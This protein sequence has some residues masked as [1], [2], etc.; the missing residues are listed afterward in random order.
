MKSRAFTLI[1]LLVVIAIIALLVGILLP[2]L[3]KARQASRLSV[4][5]SN[6]RQQMIATHTYRTDNR[7]RLPMPVV[8]LPGSPAAIAPNAMG[9][10]YSDN[11]SWYGPNRVPPNSNARPGSF[12]YWPGERVLNPYIYP[13]LDLPKRPTSPQP[14]VSMRRAGSYEAF[15]SP[16]DL[17][18][19]FTDTGPGLLFNPQMTTYQDIGSSYSMNT[20]WFISYINYSPRPFG[21][22][23]N[24]PEQWERLERKASRMIGNGTTNTSKFVW[25]FDKTAL[26]FFDSSNP[27]IEGEFMGKNKCVMGF[28]DGHADYV[29][30][31]RRTVPLGGH[32]L[33]PRG[34]GNLQ[35]GTYR[36]TNNALFTNIAEF[37]YSF[38][39][40]EFGI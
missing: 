18:T 39:L 37:E 10:N 23:Q 25:I 2:A 9:G 40:P 5:L 20:W 24:S 38:V 3:A 29:E 17:A 32:A 33:A 34:V 21:E 14:S 36:G 12:D 11:N 4:S 19:V 28:M 27:N 35:T 31:K 26:G 8:R 1:E 7:D 30:L 13:N 16:G 22:A 15:K 6:V